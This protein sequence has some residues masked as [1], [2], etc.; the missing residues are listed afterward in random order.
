MRSLALPPLWR[1]TARTLFHG[2]G[3]P[4]ACRYRKRGS[5]MSDGTIF[6]VRVVVDGSP[7][8]SWDIWFS[9]KAEFDAFLMQRPKRGI[10]VTDIHERD[11]CTVQRALEGC[12]ELIAESLEEQ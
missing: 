1:P 7:D 11:T 8:F 4:R 2:F 12:E 6:M 10:V 3:A 5:A 9:D